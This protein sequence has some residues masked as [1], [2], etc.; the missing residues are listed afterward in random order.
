MQKAMG[1][2]KDA[3]PGEEVAVIVLCRPHRAEIPSEPP[4]DVAGGRLRA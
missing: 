1:Y 4:V 2:V 3:A